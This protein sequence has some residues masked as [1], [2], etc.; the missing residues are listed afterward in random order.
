[1]KLGDSTLPHAEVEGGSWT[2]ASV[3]HAI[4]ATADE[5][6]KELLA[7]ARKIPESPLAEAQADD[8]VLA[9]GAIVSK[10]DASRAVSIAE[11]MR[12]GGLRSHR[13]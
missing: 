12:H 5:I 8:V 7:L 1:M 13:A 2:A 11:A 10:T 9:D 6:R 3:S 4:A